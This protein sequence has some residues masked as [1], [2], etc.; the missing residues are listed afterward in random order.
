MMRYRYTDSSDARSRVEALIPAIVAAAPHIDADHELPAGL[1]DA[2]FGAE[3]FR[4]LLPRKS[5]DDGASA[6]QTLSI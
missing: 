3:M 4:L 6:R 1:L 2:L 5:G